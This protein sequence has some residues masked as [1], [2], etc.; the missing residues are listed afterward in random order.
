MDFNENY[1]SGF[2]KNSVLHAGVSRYKKKYDPKLTRS[3]PYNF[4]FLRRVRQSMQLLQ[5][6]VEFEVADWMVQT[7]DIQKN[8]DVFDSV[9]EWKKIPNMAA[10]PKTFSPAVI[11]G[12]FFFVNFH[13]NSSGYRSVNLKVK[14]LLQQFNKFDKTANNNI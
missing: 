11:F 2:N 6:I 4:S 12:Y 7:H 5:A 14:L 10:G 9:L 1:Y 13:S 3:A 8:F